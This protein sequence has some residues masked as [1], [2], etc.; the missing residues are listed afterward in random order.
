MTEKTKTSYQLC[1]PT[2]EKAERCPTRRWHGCG[3]DGDE[4]NCMTRKWIPFEEYQKLE[5]KLKEAEEVRDFNTERLQ[6]ALAIMTNG[7]KKLEAELERINKKMYNDTDALARQLTNMTN[8]NIDLKAKIDEAL[9]IL[10]ELPPFQFNAHIKTLNTVIAEIL[11]GLTDKMPIAKKITQYDS[12]A[13]E[14][15]TIEVPDQYEYS[16][17]FDWVDANLARWRSTLSPVPNKK[18]NNE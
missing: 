3:G 16:A 15:W 18:M 1:N 9:K 13:D 2:P 10:D 5:S 11:D 8:A 14:S 6:S 4:D 12:I 17:F 7:Y